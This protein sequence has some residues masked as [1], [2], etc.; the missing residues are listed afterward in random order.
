MDTEEELD[1][2]EQERSMNTKVKSPSLTPLEVY[3]FI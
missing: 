3:L 2:N 1:I